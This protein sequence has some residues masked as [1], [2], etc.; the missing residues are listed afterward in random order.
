[1]LV[2]EEVREAGEGEEEEEEEEEGKVRLVEGV[3]PL[4]VIPVGFELEVD[5][6]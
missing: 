2:D 1:L 3:I 5:A 4:L 6:G